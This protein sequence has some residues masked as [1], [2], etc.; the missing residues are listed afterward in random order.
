[1]REPQPL[2]FTSHLLHL[3]AFILMC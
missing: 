3:C 1:M 2:Q